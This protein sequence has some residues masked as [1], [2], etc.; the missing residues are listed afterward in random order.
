M[1]LPPVSHRSPAGEPQAPSRAGRA[2]GSP[3]GGSF[4]AV[5]AQLG[6]AQPEGP[7]PVV[8]ADPGAHAGPSPA[9]VTL[10]FALR[11]ET[12]APA[13]LPPP[14][15]VG[16]TPDLKQTAARPGEALLLFFQ[17]AAPVPSPAADLGRTTPGADSRAVSAANTSV[18]PA[19]TA[20]R[21]PVRLAA[22]TPA[23]AV[24]P[25]AREAIVQA[26]QATRA[27]AAVPGP[28]GVP[29]AASLGPAAADRAPAGGTRLSASARP[30]QVSPSDVAA[31]PPQIAPN[32]AAGQ[33]AQ[34]AGPATPAHSTA[35]AARPSPRSPAEA[36]AAARSPAISAR[37]A[38]AAS[39]APAAAV[40]SAVIAAAATAARSTA[41]SAPLA[42]ARAQA[43]STSAGAAA[44]SLLPSA[45]S[46]KP[47]AA[48]AGARPTGKPAAAFAAPVT[49]RT[50]ASAQRTPALRADDSREAS[51]PRKSGL[52]AQSAHERT[53]HAPAQAPAA[54]SQQLQPQA[55]AR[56]QSAA[57]AQ[58]PEPSGGGL[59][60]LPPA[61]HEAVLE[62][63]SLRLT[64]LAHAANLRVTT[65][66][67]GD[68][69]VHVRV[70]DGVASLTVAGSGS[71]AAIAHSSDLRAA[72]A[73]QGLAL[74]RI[75]RASAGPAASPADAA[76]TRARSKAA[77][78]GRGHGDSSSSVEDSGEAPAAE[79]GL[80][81]SLQ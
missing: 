44:R 17:P 42:A 41:P 26:Q 20:K 61:L 24:R 45:S 74:G 56:A 21:D 48:T 49:S 72:L 16:G 79:S 37:T 7:A 78:Q 1:A 9:S 77:S 40:R 69:S 32:V 36:P 68:L 64:V 8:A 76:G 54:T 23:A 66:D 15:G 75:D 57:A 65:P 67:G 52:R 2:P 4:A 39:A 43:A 38:P 81:R 28:V 60:S 58:P 19:V 33:P 27:A 10:P 6:R 22:A 3:G 55:V 31:R 12:A 63:S 25:G 35:P 30:T 51:T 14:R 46:R 5:L 70:R 34:V 29:R 18:P 53:Q 50:A 59:A 11:E 80:A 13:L 47:A 62:D 71:D 73:G